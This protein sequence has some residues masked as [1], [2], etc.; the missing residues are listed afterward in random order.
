MPELPEVETVRRG[1]VPYLKHQVI[2][3]VIIREHR[4]RW[5]IP[6]TLATILPHQQVQEINRRGKYLLF[7]CTEGYLLIHLGMSGSLR[8]LPARAT[9]QK[10]DHLDI[11]F[12]P[13]ICLR[14]NDPRRFGCVLWTTDILNHP[15]LNSLGPEPLTAELT[16]KYL[17]Q[18]AQR[19]QTAVKNY[20]M[21]SHVVVGVGNIY[22]NE[23]LFLAGIHPATIAHEI[24]RK[25][26][27]RLV[28]KI[29]QVLTV[30]IE[31]GGTTLR[32]FTNSEG[33]PGNFKSWL[34]VYDRV[35][36]PCVQCG[37]TIQLMKIGQRASYFCPQ[38]QR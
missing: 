9:V 35:G 32:D 23:T 31:M 8:V 14:Y 13:Q 21:D 6:P 7:Q 4:L 17:Y 18:L 1:L 16:G 10:H 15:L 33:G 2:K 5:P 36:E 27:Q 26:Y 29:Q 37:S 24:S 22:A 11:V 28:E 3:R 20:I 19:R 34:K 12:T 38:C 25:R 30:A